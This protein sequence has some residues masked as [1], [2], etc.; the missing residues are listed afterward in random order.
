MKLSI[1]LLIGTAFSDEDYKQCLSKQVPV[2]FDKYNPGPIPNGK[3]VCKDN[4]CET[5]CDSTYHWYNGHRKTKCKPFGT[6]GTWGWTNRLG[7]CKT[8]GELKINRDDINVTCFL[9]NW[10]GTQKKFCKLQCP[11]NLQTAL[12]IKPINKKKV[13]A[14]CRCVTWPLHQADNDGKCHWRIGNKVIDNSDFADDYM[15]N[16]YCSKRIENPK[17]EADEEVEVPTYRI[18]PNL[19]CKQ[20]GGDRIVGG[21]AAIPHSWPW[22]MNMSFGAFVCAGTII[23]DE[24]V[25]TAAHCCDGYHR[26]PQYVRGTIGDHNW[27]EQE[28]GQQSYKATKLILHPD[29]SRRTIANDICIVKFPPMGLARRETAAPACLP[30][31]GYTVPHG[32]RCWTAGWG[33]MSNGR[34][35]DVLQEVDLKVISDEQCEKTK[36]SGYLVKGAMMCVGWLEGGK[37]GCQGDSGGPLICQDGDKQPILTGVTSWGFGCGTK[38][39]PGV[40]TKVSS[41]VEW[42]EGHKIGGHLLD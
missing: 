32:T 17:K 40:W 41:Y 15:E 30:P 31:A 26:R 23:D 20:N 9:R 25:V 10:G 35:A 5:V 24:T 13:Y 33:I 42:L 21:M 7:E 37:D 16:M 6:G 12:P 27:M 29:Y 8:C 28:H 11:G 1:G 4:A 22:I 19:V 38:N 36:N 39:S 3:V 18:P 34:A 2:G 14:V